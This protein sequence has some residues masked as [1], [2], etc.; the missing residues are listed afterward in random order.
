ME[1]E[2]QQQQGLAKQH[3]QEEVAKRNANVNSVKRKEGIK[4]PTESAML[5]LDLTD[6]KELKWM[7][8]GG[9]GPRSEYVVN[10]RNSKINDDNY[11]TPLANQVEELD[12]VE[13]INHIHTN[14]AKENCTPPSYRLPFGGP[15]SS[16][17][18]L[19]KRRAIK[20]MEKKILKE[21]ILNYSGLSPFPW[22]YR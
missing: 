18:R 21:R 1:K 22:C 12:L 8:E 7:N 13:E 2:Y 3:Q 4:A 9:R 19:S 11:W 17:E 10:N 14:S 20:R 6:G 15:T 5:T 16:G